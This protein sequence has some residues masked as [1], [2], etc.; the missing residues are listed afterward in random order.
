MIISAIIQT[1]SEDVVNGRAAES[2]VTA[3]ATKLNVPLLKQ[4]ITDFNSQGRPKQNRIAKIF[5]PIEL[6]IAIFA[7]L[8]FFTTKTL[9]MRSGI[10]APAAKIVRPATVSGS[11]NV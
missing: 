9:D 2:M 1:N 8:A 4:L 7:L 11:P 6:Q 5:D 10:E 3:V